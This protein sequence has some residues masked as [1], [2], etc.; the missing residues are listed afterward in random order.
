MNRPRWL[1]AI[2]L[3]EYGTQ[4]AALSLPLLPSSLS[5]FLSLRRFGLRI[6][7]IFKLCFPWIEARCNISQLS[8][9]GS[10]CDNNDYDIATHSTPINVK[11][12]LETK[13]IHDAHHARIY[14]AVTLCRLRCDH[15]AHVSDAMLR[16]STSTVETIHKFCV[17]KIFCCCSKWIN[18]ICG[19]LN[20]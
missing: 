5:L 9:C 17:T 7:A 18:L 13:P 16:A 4:S 1:N 19:Q 2:I 15:E 11:S 20:K 8:G 6:S 10:A 12:I 3:I 14:A